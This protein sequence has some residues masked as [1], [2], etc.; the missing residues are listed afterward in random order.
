MEDYPRYDQPP[1]RTTAEDLRYDQP[2]AGAST[3]DLRYDQPYARAGE[4]T[5]GRS[6]EEPLV[7]EERWGDA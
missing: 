2:H 7:R 4:Q 1:A 3:E 6:S 5:R